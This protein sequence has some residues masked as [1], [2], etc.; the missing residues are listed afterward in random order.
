MPFQGLAL[1]SSILRKSDLPTTAE[2]GIDAS[3]LFSLLQQNS[4]QSPN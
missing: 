1:F 3:L 2:Y 4:L